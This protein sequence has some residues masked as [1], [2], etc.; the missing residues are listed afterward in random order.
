MSNETI[1]KAADGYKLMRLASTKK[2][3]IYKTLLAQQMKRLCKARYKGSEKIPVDSCTIDEL[4]KNCAAD[5][6]TYITVVT[7]ESKDVEEIQYHGGFATPE[8]RDR[9]QARIAELEKERDNLEG[10]VAKYDNQSLDDQTT[11]KELKKKRDELES[12]LTRCTEILGERYDPAMGCNGIMVVDKHLE[13]II[14]DLNE[15]ERVVA[16]AARIKKLLPDELEARSSL[17]HRQMLNMEEG[18]FA[19]WLT[20]F[21]QE[22]ENTMFRQRLQEEYGLDPQT[23]KAWVL[24]DDS[25]SIAPY[26]VKTIMEMARAKYPEWRYVVGTEDQVDERKW[27]L[28]EPIIH[29]T[30]IDRATLLDTMQRMEHLGRYGR[31]QAFLLVPIDI[32]EAMKR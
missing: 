4:C 20:N 15:H 29:E 8:E 21:H 32:D 1:I 11:I 19:E 6:H 2:V 10:V 3:H 25:S 9:L 17:V 27:W 13:S 30:R 23:L 18:E 7:Q 16:K 12:V 22:R 5:N 14:A 28:R 31:S 24:P 26:A